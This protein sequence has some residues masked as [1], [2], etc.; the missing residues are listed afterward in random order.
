MSVTTRQFSTGFWTEEAVEQ[1]LTTAEEK[2]L[3]IYIRNNISTALCGFFQF[4]PATA[5]G[6]TT[7]T[8]QRIT[9]IIG[10]LETVGLIV[11]DR[12]YVFVPNF[13][14][15]QNAVSWM[16]TNDHI[17]KQYQ[18]FS[19]SRANPKNRAFL[20]FCE[21]FKEILAT[22]PQKRERKKRK[23]SEIEVASG[24]T[25]PGN[26]S[27]S[28]AQKSGSFALP[29]FEQVRVHFL[30][31]R[32][33]AKGESCPDGVAQAGSFYEWYSNK[34]LTDEW[35][36]KADQWCARKLEEAAKRDAEDHG[37]ELPSGK[38]LAL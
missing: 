38:R 29:P 24:G 35:N 20:A 9:E 25:L 8:F 22:P 37:R 32:S 1:D 21:R 4:S 34:G 2:L 18:Q 5:A 14:E 30:N 23:T 28:S 10:K 31:W 12:G 11:Y 26:N 3:W 19:M 17:H 33:R 36:V 6:Q 27:N 16:G 7:I 15:E 13:L